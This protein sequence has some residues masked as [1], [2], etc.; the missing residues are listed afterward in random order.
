MSDELAVGAPGAETEEV[1]TTNHAEETADAKPEGGE[2][3]PQAN[4]NDGEQEHKR[5]GGWQR[6]IQKLERELQLVKSQQSAPVK[7]EPKAEPFTYD[8]A[9]PDPKDFDLGDGTYDVAKYTRAMISYERDKA[10]AEDAHEQKHKEAVKQTEDEKKKQVEVVQSWREKN[11]D[12]IKQYDDF[13]EVLGAAEVV[14]SPLMHEAILNSDHGAD[15][16]YY[17]GT[18]EEEALKISQMNAYQAGKA[19]DK[20]EAQFAK[21]DSAEDTEDKD[22]APPP[23]PTLPAPP[24][25]VRRPSAAPTK[26]ITDDDLPFKEFVK[27]RNAQEAKKRT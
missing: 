10:K 11:A 5:L 9:E 3:D 7:E 22:P 13:D 25:Q 23:K 1:V 26:S 20:I 24:T 6:K 21:P 8:K 16:A 18:H 12:A 2:A 17:F 27:L 19:I 14:P 4:A 15:L